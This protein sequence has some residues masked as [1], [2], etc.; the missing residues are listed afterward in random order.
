MKNILLVIALAASTGLAA[1]STNEL[2]VTNFDGT[3]VTAAEKVKSLEANRNRI[4]DLTSKFLWWRD[5]IRDCA[6]AMIDYEKFKLLDGLKE[7]SDWCKDNDFLKKA[8]GGHVNAEKTY[9]ELMQTIK[10]VEL[11]STDEKLKKE[12][13]KIKQKV[14]EMKAN[15]KIVKWLDSYF[16]P[17]MTAHGTPLQ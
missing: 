11:L 10:A 15:D 6:V 16:I 14:I 13:Q 2:V 7:D 12:A 3:V 9:N 1:Q 5:N 8:K 17:K 4:D